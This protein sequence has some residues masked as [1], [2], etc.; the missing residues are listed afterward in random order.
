MLAQININLELRS[1]RFN[2]KSNIF[3]IPDVLNM[4]FDIYYTLFDTDGRDLSVIKD[5][6]SHTKSKL[7]RIKDVEKTGYLEVGPVRE[8]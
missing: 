6:W 2:W 8:I 1:A 5:C 4:E 7:R 3:S